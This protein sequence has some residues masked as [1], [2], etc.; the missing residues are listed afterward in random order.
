MNQKQ[1]NPELREASSIHDPNE[2][3]GITANG[4]KAGLEEESDPFGW[5]KTVV[6]VIAQYAPGHEL[7]NPEA[8]PLLTD[9]DG[10]KSISIFHEGK[11]MIV[12]LGHRPGETFANEA[13]AATAELITT[14]KKGI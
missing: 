2:Q 13:H 4:K 12:H 6:Q 9:E 8:P 3:A 14:L 7:Y 10:R 5:V 1:N 11:V